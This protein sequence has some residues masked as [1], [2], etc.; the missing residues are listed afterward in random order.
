MA[1]SSGLFNPTKSNITADTKVIVSQVTKWVENCVSQSQANQP[2]NSYNIMVTEVQCNDPTCVPIETLVV[3]IGSEGKKYSD[4][5][6]KPIREV[7]EDDVKYLLVESGLFIM[8][9]AET[10]KG[11][12]IDNILSIMTKDILNKTLLLKK[13]SDRLSLLDKLSERINEE[14]AELMKYSDSNDESYDDMPPLEEPTFVDPAVVTKE[15]PALVTSSTLVSMKP[16]TSTAQPSAISLSAPKLIVQS[17]P[18]MPPVRH[19]KG[20]RGPR[21]CPCCDP[22]NLENIADRILFLDCPP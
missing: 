16:K 7:I 19:E 2:T 4:K 22:D 13:D 5:I 8:P 15:E 6:A 14:R 18:S 1:S 12:Y 20:I 21:G 17:R 3:L 10:L 9:D 11:K